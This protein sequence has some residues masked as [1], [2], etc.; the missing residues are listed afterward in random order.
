MNRVNHRPHALFS[1]GVLTIAALCCAIIQNRYSVDRVGVLVFAFMSVV[2]I[3]FALAYAALQQKLNIA[4]RYTCIVVSVMA[5]LFTLWN[6]LFHH[7]NIDWG[8]VNAGEQRLS[9]FQQIVRSSWSFLLTYLLPFIISI[10]IFLR[11][12]LQA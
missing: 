11:R 4:F 5:I 2:N 6:Y 12:R 7:L 1:L 9:W 8:A 10:F 3:V